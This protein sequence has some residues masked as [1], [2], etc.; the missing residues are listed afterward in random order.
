MIPAKIIPGEDLRYHA[1][2]TGEF[3]IPNDL[4][5]DKVDAVTNIRDAVLK[6]PIEARWKRG[7]DDTWWCDILN[8]PADKLNE[9]LQTVQLKS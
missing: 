9:T 6:I 8:L 4:S 1:H 7:W 3:P 5:K 2:D